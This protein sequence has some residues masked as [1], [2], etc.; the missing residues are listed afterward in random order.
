[1]SDDHDDDLTATITA[2][3]SQEYL[4]QLKKEKEERELSPRQKRLKEK[5]ERLG[6]EKQALPAERKRREKSKEEIARE[7]EEEAQA[8]KV[9]TIPQRIMGGGIDLAVTAI[10]FFIAKNEKIMAIA[11]ENFFKI[12]EAAGGVKL[13]LSDTM[14]DY[15]LIGM[16]FSVMYF[17]VQVCLTWLTQKSIGKMVAK[18]HLVSFDSDKVGLFQAIKRELILKPIGVCFLVGFIM[19]FF[20]EDN[21]SFHDR[22]GGTIVAKD[23]K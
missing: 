18:T 6:L 14:L 9:A 7:K 1:M 5:S 20:S 8:M 2:K 13:E 3:V 23:R 12:L 15:I 22:F 4:E 16:T 17:F 11:E 10:L 21:E 19:P